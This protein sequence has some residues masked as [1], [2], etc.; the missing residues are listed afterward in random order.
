[1]ELARNA[2]CHCGSGVKYKKCCLPK[3]AATAR[4]NGPPAPKPWMVPPARRVAASSQP[5]D[6]HDSPR[7]VNSPKPGQEVRERTPPDPL[8]E[9]QNAMWERFESSSAGEQFT[10][11]AAAMDEPGLMDRE[12]AFDMLSTLFE[13]ASADDDTARFDA[14]VAALRA[15]HPEVYREEARYIADW[16][17]DSALARADR[18]AIAAAAGEIAAVAP[19]EPELLAQAMET[20]AFHGYARLIA[21]M[22]AVA[23]RAAGDDAE[24]AHHAAVV[25]RALRYAALDAL[26]RG[27]DASAPAP[28]PGTPL[29][30]FPRRRMSTLAPW[31]RAVQDGAIG[32]ITLADVVRADAR[33]QRERLGAMF[34][35]FLRREEGVPLSLGALGAA[36]LLAYVE[37]RLR[38]PAR[39]GESTR[40]RRRDIE[41]GGG[42]ASWLVPTHEALDRFLSD[43]FNAVFGY[44]PHAAIAMLEVLPAWLRFLAACGLL[45]DP[46]TASTL[47]G[48]SRVVETARRIVSKQQSDRALAAALV[49]WPRV[50][51]AGAR[52]P[53][54]GDADV[55]WVIPAIERAPRPPRPPIDWA[56]AVEGVPVEDFFA[57]TPLDEPASRSEAIDNLVHDLERGRFLSWEAVIREEQGQRLTAAEAEAIEGLLNFNEGDDADDRVRYID[58]SARPGEPWYALVARAAEHLD[59]LPLRT[60]EMHDAGITEAWPRLI[61]AIAAHAGPLSLPPGVLR[62][63]EVVPAQLRLRLELQ[64]CIEPLLG[65]GQQGI[66]GGEPI[67]L[68]DTSELRRIDEFIDRLRAHRVSVAGVGLTLANLSDFVV[69]PHVDAERLRRALAERLRLATAESSIA[70]ALAAD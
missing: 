7:L 4:A 3:D 30:D 70:D 37:G 36:E 50:P 5:P 1:M 32:P 64:A 10:V 22:A 60:D 56:Q 19:D 57:D 31:L 25:D 62:P 21:T 28:P 41:H 53:A 51:R 15:Q 16:L 59:A 12:M 42:A 54:A 58:E 9:R 17:L 34:L 61:E 6:R 2:P 69:L 26:E 20:L 49:D 13:T 43:H 35:G 67:K 18:A 66:G 8:V 55:E 27:M 45:A 23:L 46:D 14:A 11:F 29:A 39:D 40:K 65:I 48:V 63:I 68:A 47:R 52:L 33:E 24:L 38:Q 44:R